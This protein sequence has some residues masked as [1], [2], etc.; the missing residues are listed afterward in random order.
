MLHDVLQKRNQF[1]VIKHG[2]AKFTTMTFQQKRIFQHPT[3]PLFLSG[4]AFRF[5]R[6]S[7]LLVLTFPRLFSKVCNVNRNF[8]SKTAEKQT[9]LCWQRP[10]IHQPMDDVSTW[11]I[12]CM[13]V[14]GLSISAQDGLHKLKFNVFWR[15][16]LPPS[17]LSKTRITFQSLQ[18]YAEKYGT[19][20][21]AWGPRAKQFTTGE[22]NKCRGSTPNLLNNSN[23]G[24]MLHST[25]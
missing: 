9:I 8:Q 18:Y 22:S 25:S 11:L 20:K 2:C 16:S 14:T 17:R 4:I 23:T 7:R 21:K 19:F 15:P 1:T 13:S 10:A 6:I 3:I 24:Q 12:Q 5:M